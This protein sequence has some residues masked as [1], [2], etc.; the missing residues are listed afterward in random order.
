VTISSPVLCVGDVQ[1]TTK[2]A[3]TCDLI[4]FPLSKSTMYYDSSVAHLMI[5]VDASLFVNRSFGGWFAITLI[6]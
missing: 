1:F 3:K 2:S 4:A 6:L 5:Q